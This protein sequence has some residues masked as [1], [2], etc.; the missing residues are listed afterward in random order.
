MAKPFKTLRDKMAPEAR[1]RAAARTQRML[2]EMDLQELR[3]NIGQLTQ[4]EVAEILGATQAHVSK[5]ERRPDML[6]SSLR[7]YIEAMGGRLDVRARFGNR[8]VRIKSLA[9]LAEIH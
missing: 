2:L 9:D 6:L 7:A 5:L 8:T 3:E 1:K 4:T